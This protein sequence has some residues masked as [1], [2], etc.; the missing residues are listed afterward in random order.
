MKSTTTTKKKGPKYRTAIILVNKQIK[1]FS[2]IPTDPSKFQVLR[3][4]HRPSISMLEQK[5]FFATTAT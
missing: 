4:C 3:Q 1:K 5:D 2:A